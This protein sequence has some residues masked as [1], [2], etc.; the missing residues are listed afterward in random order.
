MIIRFNIRWIR[1]TFTIAPVTKV[2]GVNSNLDEQKKWHILMWDFDKTDLLTI[3]LHLK[4][5]QDQYKLPNIY[6]LKT[7]KNNYIA[8]CFRRS[9]W[10]EAIHI[11]SAHPNV[12]MNFLKYSVYRGHFTLRISRKDS[13]PKPRLVVVL[14]SRVHETASIEDLKSFTIYETIRPGYR[15]K[16]IEVGK[17]R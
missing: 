4:R 13:K 7:S 10:R 11:V 6:I 17:T 16:K 9:T 2:V 14:P 5:I 12:D 1:I 8:Y 15:G 3:I